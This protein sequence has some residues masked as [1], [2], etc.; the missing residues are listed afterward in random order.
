[1]DDRQLYEKILGLSA[2]WSVEEVELNTT[3][4]EVVVRLASSI[5]ALVCPEC[6]KACPGYDTKER[7]WRHL[8]TCQMTTT[9][10]AKIPRVSC[11]EHGVLQVVVPWAEGRSRFTALFEALAITWLKVA[12][13]K[14]VAERLRLSWDEADGIMQRAVVRGLARKTKRLPTAIGVD[15]T[16][17]QKRHAYVTIVNDLGGGVEYVADGRG[18]EVLAAFY[19]QFE[20]EE[21][22]S[23][24]VVAMD[25]H[26]PY[27]SATRKHIP[28]AD[29]KIAFDK[30]HV[31][32]HLG[33][34]VDSVRREEHASLQRAGDDRLKHTRYLWLANPTEM[35]AEKFA[36]L[37][38]IKSRVV[39]TGRAW[40]LKEAA[41]EIWSIR[42][43]RA[44][45]AA[46]TA[47][48]NWSIR[49]KLEPMKK[50][51]R[52]IKSHIDGIVVAMVQRV[53]NAKA[54]GTNAVIQRIK[55]AA[56]GFRNR[57]RFH[58]AIYFHC[59]N[60]DLY[61]TCIK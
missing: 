1:M 41:M 39:R 22:A 49:S 3:Q 2:P 11:V 42:R 51:A 21:L 48:Y 38:Q 26:A 8:D 44:A 55:Y 56:R 40:T 29:S 52:M 23:V 47:W 6:G 14:A 34:A 16:S 18:E 24:R 17:Y 59:G 45:R 33:D 13:I 58:N 35:S 10:V 37:E 12:P 5:D 7:R 61:P 4:Q 54:E 53:S 43:P 60:L 20:E 50:V 30:F 46:L 28:G 36:T 19:R 27:I 9:L 15:E 57:K 31:A 32:K 25:M